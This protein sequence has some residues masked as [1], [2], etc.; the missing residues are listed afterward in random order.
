MSD[1]ESFVTILHLSS[2]SRNVRTQFQYFSI[3]STKNLSMELS[4]TY[5]STYI[6]RS[7]YL[8]IIRNNRYIHTYVHTY[9]VSK[10]S[11]GRKGSGFLSR[12]ITAKRKYQS[13]NGKTVFLSLHLLNNISLFIHSEW[14]RGC[15]CKVY[16]GSN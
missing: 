14:S 3:L 7:K 15:D 2:T 16:G 1:Y 6:G 8:L 4:T 9:V 10:V 13:N 12:N 5:V 11:E